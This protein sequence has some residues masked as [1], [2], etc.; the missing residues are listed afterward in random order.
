[1]PVSLVNE[2]LQN[3]PL[4]A[5]GGYDESAVREGAYRRIT[6][7]RQHLDEFAFRPRA[8]GERPAVCFTVPCL[9]CLGAFR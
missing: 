7:L 5:G 9:V 3:L 4:L 8:I 2:R 1:M 6:H